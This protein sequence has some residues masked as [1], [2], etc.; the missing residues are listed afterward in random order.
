MDSPPPDPRFYALRSALL[1]GDLSLADELIRSDPASLEA[2]DG[3]GET[4]LHWLAVEDERELVEWLRSRGAQVDPR[5]HF[6]NTPLGE[7]ASLGYLELCAYLVAHGADTRA[8]NHL[9]S[10]PLAQAATSD[11]LEV[12]MYLLKQVAGGEDLSSYFGP[13]DL[14]LHVTPD[15]AVAGVLREAGLSVGDTA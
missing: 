1:D 5:T 8:K 14:E 13:Y 11:Q 9:G 6:G 15:S 3:V 12:V 2:R 7:A 10:T 4:V